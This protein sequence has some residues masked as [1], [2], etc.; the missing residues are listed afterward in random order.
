MDLTKLSDDDLD[1]LNRGKLDEL[2]DEGLAHISKSANTANPTPEGANN[3]FKTANNIQEAQSISHQGQGMAFGV[4]DSPFLK[5]FKSETDKGF[6]PEGMQQMGNNL[7]LAEG[8]AGAVNVAA[9][10]PEAAMWAASKIPGVGSIVKILKMGKALAPTA[11]EAAPS[12]ADAVKS[13][14]SDSTPEASKMAEGYMGNSTPV[15]SSTKTSIKF[16]PGLMSKS[17]K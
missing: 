10:A 4:M 3:P 11:E 15:A 12:L 13:A 9:K 16:I 2:S 7:A 5:S 14:V 8:G 6:S 1:A 17:L